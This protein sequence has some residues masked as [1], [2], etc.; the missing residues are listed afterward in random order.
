MKNTEEEIALQGIEFWS[1]VCDEE[2]DLSLEAAEAEEVFLNQ[3]VMAPK[4]V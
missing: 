3:I 1:S 4:V 2:I